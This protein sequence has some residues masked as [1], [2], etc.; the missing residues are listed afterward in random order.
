MGTNPSSQHV[1]SQAYFS[2]SLYLKTLLLFIQWMNIV[3]E[4]RKRLGKLAV[5]FGRIIVRRVALNAFLYTNLIS[6]GFFFCS[7]GEDISNKLSLS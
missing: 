1:Y 2:A 7:P 5:A 4:K 6:C 3:E